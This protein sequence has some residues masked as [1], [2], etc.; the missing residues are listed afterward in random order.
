MEAGKRAFAAEEL[1][2]VAL[3]LRKPVAYF[4]RA[5]AGETIELPAG[6]SVDA[7]A[8]AS[9]FRGDADAALGTIYEESEAARRELRELEQR[10]LAI[11]TVAA[12]ASGAIRVEGDLPG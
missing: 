12:T 4:F 10:I 8:L 11:N 5:A 3:V 7:A 6:P 1:V 2:A 9:L